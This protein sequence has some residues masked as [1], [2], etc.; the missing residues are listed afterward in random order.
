M[1][2]T[3]V[4]FKREFNSYFTNPLAFI[5]L[6]CFL[7]MNGII[8]WV[9]V[10]I[11]NEPSAPYGAALRLFFGG[12]FFFWLFLFVFIPVITMKLFS[13]ELKTGSIELLITAPVSELQIALGKFL[14]AFIFYCF[15]W[16]P[17]ISYP[18]IL[19]IFSTIEIGPT[20]SGYFGVLLIGAFFI[21]IGMFC[22]TLARSQIS[23]AI[24][25]FTVLVAL[26]IIGLLKAIITDP[27]LIKI[28]DYINFMEMMETFGKGII[29]TRHLIFLTTATISLIFVNIKFLETRKW[30]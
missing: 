22:S 2:K 28:F 7:L 15:L 12:T 19:R 24:M 8:F 13:E 16:I 26:F 5:T 6:T 20:I 29:D 23:A 3:L 27:N 9:L 14:A 4:I 30:V 11:L 25:T 18:L 21:S 17:T 10:S 1:F